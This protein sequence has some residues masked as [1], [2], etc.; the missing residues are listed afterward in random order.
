[1]KFVHTEQSMQQLIHSN[2][3]RLCTSYEV[4]VPN[5][6]SRHDNECD[7]YAI[8][9]SGLCDEIEIK[10]S[11]ADFLKDSKKHVAY[12]RGTRE[13]YKGLQSL[14]ETDKVNAPRPWLKPKHEC[15]SEGLLSNYYWYVVKEGIATIDEVP[16]WA[17]FVTV[18]D[19][20]RIRVHRSAKRLH[21]EKLSLED[22]YKTAKKM[23]YRYWNLLS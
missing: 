13:E 18:D 5:C 4:V 23:Y 6:Y 21:K 3:Q 20:G 15:L 14:S 2:Q 9:K 1:M 19:D 22:C 11:R 10:V 8:R 7:L 17:G 16:E 12:R